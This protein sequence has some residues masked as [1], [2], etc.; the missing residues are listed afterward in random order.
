MV[1]HFWLD[2]QQRTPAH[3]ALVG[4]C[5]LELP[6]DNPLSPANVRF[7]LIWNPGLC[8]WKIGHGGKLK[9]LKRVKEHPV[10]T[11]NCCL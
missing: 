9:P 5:V 7:N 8:L 1:D 4:S 11:G 3:F 2:H 6:K 10:W